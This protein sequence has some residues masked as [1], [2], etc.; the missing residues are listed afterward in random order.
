MGHSLKSESESE[1][2]EILEDVKFK[3]Q[4]AFL[5]WFCAFFQKVSPLGLKSPYRF[6]RL[7]IVKQIS[8][9]HV[10]MKEYAYKVIGAFIP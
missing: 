8:P 3:S 2:S 6:P 10:Y 4:R 7:S 1:S 5:F 9:N